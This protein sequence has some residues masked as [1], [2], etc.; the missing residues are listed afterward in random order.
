MFSIIFETLEDAD[1]ARLRKKQI[2]RRAFRI[3]GATRA[4]SNRAIIHEVVGKHEIWSVLNL[5]VS[6]SNPSHDGSS[7]RCAY[8]GD[9]RP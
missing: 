9:T 2:K 8:R 6:N 7:C 4:R 1:R 5:V 3:K